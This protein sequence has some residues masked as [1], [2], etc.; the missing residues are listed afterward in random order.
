VVHDG[1]QQYRMLTFVIVFRIEFHSSDTRKYFDKGHSE[2][3]DGN[4]MT[5]KFGM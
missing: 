5:Q 1:L 4:K 3:V 2:L